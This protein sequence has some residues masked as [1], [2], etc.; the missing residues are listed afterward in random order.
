ML[1]GSTPERFGAWLEA[2]ARQVMG[3]PDPDE[4][5]VF[6][7]AWNEWAEGTYLEPDQ[8]YGCAYLAA[9]AAALQRVANDAAGEADLSLLR[10]DSAKHLQE[11]TSLARRGA[12]RLA[13][14]LN[15][16]ANEK[17]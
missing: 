1:V 10:D 17:R 8:H 16:F 13:R 15:A 3:N 9:A 5:V 14:W 6:I 11:S 4:R 12:R 7:N 2:A